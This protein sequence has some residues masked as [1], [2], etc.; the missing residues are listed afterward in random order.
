MESNHFY[1]RTAFTAP[2]IPNLPTL[3]K[4]NKARETFVEVYICLPL[5]FTS[6]SPAF[7]LTSYLV[8]SVSLE[9]TSLSA[10][11]PKSSVFTDFTTSG[12]SSLVNYRLT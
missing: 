9:L 5:G 12:W 7:T 10:L 2:R 8:R 11:D 4:T 1:F 6:Q 3:R